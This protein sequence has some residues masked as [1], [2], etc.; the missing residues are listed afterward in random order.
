MH[1]I[2]TTQVATQNLRIAI[3]SQLVVIFTNLLI[4][5]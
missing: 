5:S 3:A 4:A 2:Y 1:I